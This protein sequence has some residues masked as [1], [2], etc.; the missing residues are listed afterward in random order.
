VYLAEVSKGASVWK[1]RSASLGV[2]VSPMSAR[3]TVQL[4]TPPETLNVTAETVPQAQPPPR[5]RCR[6]PFSSM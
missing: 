3:L 5:W 4:V 6:N 1:T 2:A